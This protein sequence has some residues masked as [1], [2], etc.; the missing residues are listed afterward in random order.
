V[1]PQIRR[2]QQG[3]AGDRFTDFSIGSGD[4]KRL[5]TFN[6]SCKKM[7]RQRADALLLRPGQ[8]QRAVC[9]GQAGRVR[10]LV[11]MRGADALQRAHGAQRIGERQADG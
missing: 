4:K 8:L 9:P 7:I 3:A 2:L 5:V 6:D 1:F 10:P 11:Q